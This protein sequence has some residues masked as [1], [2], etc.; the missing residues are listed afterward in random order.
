M[1]DPVRV[2]ALNDERTV[3]LGAVLERRGRRGPIDT[4]ATAS[5]PILVL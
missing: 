1:L 3:E 4:S 2:L 5:R